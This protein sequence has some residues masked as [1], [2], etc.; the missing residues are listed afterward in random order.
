MDKF[1]IQWND[2]KRVKSRNVKRTWDVKITPN[3]KNKDKRR[4]AVRF[5]FL[6]EAAKVF[7]DEKYI[8]MSKITGNRI[9]FRC[10]DTKAGNCNMTKLSPNSS[11]KTG[12]FTVFT[13][14]PEQSKLYKKRW[15]GVPFNLKYDEDNQLYYIENTN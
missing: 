8:E 6:N 2:A 11:A 4:S 12:W 7:G 15:F 13:P 1:E 9:Y 5:G 14:T 3:D 10:A